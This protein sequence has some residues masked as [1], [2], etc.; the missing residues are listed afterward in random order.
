MLSIAWN[1]D[2]KAPIFSILSKDNTIGIY[3]FRNLAINDPI[4]S[5]KNKND[6]TE[7]E[8][9]QSGSV[10]FCA[11]GDS[12]SSV[13]MMYSPQMELISDVVSLH[14]SKINSIAIDPNNQFIATCSDDSLV[15]INTLPD[16]ICQRTY[17]H[18]DCS[19][20]KVAFSSKGEYL[21]TSC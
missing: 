17:S 21:A 18:T 20:K 14:N 5:Q 15:A 13:L 7:I 10:L 19:L 1:H 12:S 11:G 6:I 4:H 16:I 8:W 9:D 3:D 2:T